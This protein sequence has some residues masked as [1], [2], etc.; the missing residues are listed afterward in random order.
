MTKKEHTIIASDIDPL[1]VK[2]AQENARIAGVEEYINFEVKD[3][4]D[5]IAWPELAGTLVSNPPYGARLNAFDLE[6]LYHTITE[7]FTHHPKLHGGIIT[8]Y[9]W[10][11]TDE[12]SGTWKK[13][14][15]FN[16]WERC[17]FYKKTLLK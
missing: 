10:F 8:S 7:V 5:H 2:I 9:E 1:V 15:F 4:K 14:M 16:G 12:V 17:Y 11:E 6:Q 13:N 3:I